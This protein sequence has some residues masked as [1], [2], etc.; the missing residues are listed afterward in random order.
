MLLCVYICVIFDC[1][2]YLF[3][4]LCFFFFNDTA[5]TEIY[6][7][8]L[9]D[10][11]PIFGAVP[12]AAAPSAAPRQPHPPPRQP[13]A[14]PRHPPPRQPPPRQASAELVSNGTAAV[15]SAAVRA[16][17]RSSFIMP[18]CSRRLSDGTQNEQFHDEFRSVQRP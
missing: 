1:I 2:F 10:A 18:S 14:A 5:T 12:T 16:V 17:V 15:I 6:T 9:H 13:T 7:L 11:L 8:S 3:S 4:L